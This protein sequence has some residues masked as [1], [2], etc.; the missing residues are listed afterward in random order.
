MASEH[1][2]SA[3]AA[4]TPI[5]ALSLLPLG[6]YVKM[7]G[8]NPGEERTGDPGEFASHPRWQRILIGLAGPVANFL[9]AFALMTGYYMMH[10]EV[11]LFLSSPA[12]LD[13]VPQDYGG[14]SCRPPGGRPDHS[15]R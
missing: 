12:V 2:C 14:G 9:L 15:V 6:G 4:A 5:T 10:N 3:S 13:F 1:G 7:A 11:E 8:E